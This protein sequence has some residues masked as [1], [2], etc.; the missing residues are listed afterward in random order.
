MKDFERVVLVHGQEQVSDY[1]DLCQIAYRRNRGVED[2]IIPCLE[3]YLFPFEKP[4]ACIRLMFYDF[5]SAFNT[6][7][8][9]LLAGKLMKMN[10]HACT[11]L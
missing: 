5:S 8:P 1:T 2:A 4:G 6:I 9:H 11:R 3:H 7:Q 10:V